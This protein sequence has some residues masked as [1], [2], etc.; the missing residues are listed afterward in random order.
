MVDSTLHIRGACAI[1]AHA[2]KLPGFFFFDPSHSQASRLLTPVALL[3]LLFSGN[4]IDVLSPAWAG[5]F[6]SR[7]IRTRPAPILPELRCVRE[8][9][10]CERAPVALRK[11]YFFGKEFRE[12]R[13]V[14]L[15]S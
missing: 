2:L 12:G 6:A 1:L 8:H 3:L 5:S 11:L 4:G 10:C 13:T 9:G 14:Q 7:R 15:V